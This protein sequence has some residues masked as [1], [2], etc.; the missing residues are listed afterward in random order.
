MVETLLL[1]GWQAW[2]TLAVVVAILVVLVLEIAPPDLV[3]LA[4]LVILAL[5]GVVT[6]RDAL[7][8]FS[9]QALLAV[10]GLFI[11]AGAVRNS[12]TL[13][14]V[15]RLLTPTSGGL[16]AAIFRVMASSAILSSVMNNTPIVAILAPTVQDRASRAGIAPSKLLIPLAYATTMG[17]MITLIGT[18]TNLVV[19][20]LLVANGMAPLSLFSLT[21]VGVAIAVGGILYF[22]LIGHRLLPDRVD[23]RRSTRAEWRAYHFELKVPAISPISGLTIEEAGLR[24]LRGAFLA[25]IHRGGERINIVGPQQ[26]LHGEDVLG[27][28]GNPQHVDELLQSGALTRVVTPP[29][30]EPDESLPL[31]EAVVAA[32]SPLV[33]HSLKEIEFRERYQGVVLGIQREGRALEG[34]LGRA[35]LQAGDLLLVEARPSFEQRAMSSG[36]FYLVAPLER[37]GLR[38]TRRAPAVLITLLAMVAAIATGVVPLTIAVFAGALIMIAIRGIS[39]TDARRSLDLSVLITIAAGFGVAR[40][41]ETSG[42]A[43]AIAKLLVHGVSAWGPIAVL[44]AVYVAT[45]ILTEILTN[46]AAAV[47]V[48]PIAVSAAAAVGADARPF[49]LAVA[50]AASAGFALPIGYQTYMM[51]LGPGGYRFRDFLK[52]GLP[53]DFIA[54]AIAIPL[55]AALWM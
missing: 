21:P 47:L 28:V 44:A 23:Q 24:S 1:L 32:H 26:Q 25:H 53:L 54:A 37:N 46:N 14:Y 55:I 6:P 20:G 15:D 13:A 38:A 18:S 12:G 31:F 52:V 8:G 22:L 40:A 27:F 43:D 36:D 33:G 19:S 34:L 48:F 49:A 41:L 17:G 51:V 7:A 4:G 9:N 45:V 30:D 35:D 2:L 5:T 3:M 39:G 29:S 42:L 16:R 50:I 11:V 10:A